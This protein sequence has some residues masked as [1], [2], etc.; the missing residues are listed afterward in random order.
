MYTPFGLRRYTASKRSFIGF[1]PR[2]RIRGSFALVVLQ[3]SQA[4]S[5]S[6]CIALSI[7]VSFA[8][9]PVGLKVSLIVSSSLS[10]SIIRSSLADV[11][12]GFSRRKEGK[13]MP[14][15]SAFGHTS[16]SSRDRRVS[17]NP[18]A[19]LAHSIQQ[20]LQRRSL[21]LI[22]RCASYV[23]VHFSRYEIF[24]I[25]RFARSLFGGSVSLFVC[26]STSIQYV[27]Y[28]RNV[29]LDPILQD[30]AFPVRLAVLFF[31][32]HLTATAISMVCVIFPS[33]T[34]AIHSDPSSRSH[35]HLCCVCV[36][37]ISIR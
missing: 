15:V 18:V 20:L 24:H 1:S 28:N 3:Q 36:R 4:S 9:L 35:L 37:A 23:F 26:L 33:F 31:P 25:S 30:L 12:A 22:F 11:A 19:R 21:C 29:F 34:Q 27:Q 13:T 8:S 2:L 32:L 17:L 10:A 16:L 5:R 14:F 6:L 7:V